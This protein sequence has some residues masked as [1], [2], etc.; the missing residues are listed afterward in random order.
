MTRRPLPSS[1]G[2][3]RAGE[4]GGPWFWREQLSVGERSR[5]VLL[6]VLLDLSAD[7]LGGFRVESAFDEEWSDEIGD[8]VKLTDPGMIQTFVA[9]ELPADL[10]NSRGRV[11]RVPED[12]RRRLLFDGGYWED[13]QPLDRLPSD[14]MLD[15][16][17][18]PPPEASDPGEEEGDRPLT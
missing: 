17:S 6:E 2:G 15:G 13:D 8:F 14:A 4:R 16:L 3:F 12:E 1:P 10:V 11:R 18:D 5:E 9:Y 7:E